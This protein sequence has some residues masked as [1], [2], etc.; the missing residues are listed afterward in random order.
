[1]NFTVRVTHKH[2]GQSSSVWQASSMERAY[3]SAMRL[4]P[5]DSVS[6]TVD[7]MTNLC[8]GT[9][10]EVYGYGN[11]YNLKHGGRIRQELSRKEVVDL[12]SKLKKNPRL[13]ILS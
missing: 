11:S 3:Q 7:W 1:M 9:T 13:N 5:G 10:A 6:V 8:E 4:Y 12:V 2:G